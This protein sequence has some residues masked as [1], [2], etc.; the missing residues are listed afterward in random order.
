MQK[1]KITEAPIKG[2]LSIESK[3]FEDSR[4]F[5]MEIFNKD[6]LAELGFNEPCV[7]TNHSWSKKGV[8]RGLHYQLNPH[9]MGK[10]IKVVTGRIFDVGVDIR[11]KSKTFGKWYGE[12]LSAENKKM[13]Y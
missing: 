9:P 10:L 1:F 8:V 6:C 13:L 11:K 4:G 7:Q 3:V 5:F 12:I 2:V